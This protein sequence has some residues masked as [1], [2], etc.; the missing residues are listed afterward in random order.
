MPGFGSYAKGGDY[1][2]VK[3]GSYPATIVGAQIVKENGQVKYHPESGKA[4]VDVTFQLD[5]TNDEGNPVELRRRMGLTY[6]KNRKTG[7][8]S[9]WAT[10]LE[11]ATGI[12]CGDKAQGHVGEEA[13]VGRRL[14]VRVKR[15][16]SNGNTYS[17]V[18]D[19]EE[20]DERDEAPL[21]DDAAELGLDEI[22]F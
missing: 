12:A 7:A 18:V 17:N 1:A 11:T 9:N 3:N 4:S 15:V 20:L 21:D 19:F 8:Y 22:P 14:T 13:L 10:F 6:G 16:E 2:P 5:I